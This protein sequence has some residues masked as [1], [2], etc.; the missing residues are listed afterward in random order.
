MDRFSLFPFIFIVLGITLAAPAQMIIAHRGASHDA[1]ENTL[2]AFNLAWEQGADGIEGDFHLTRDGKII[3]GHDKDMKR[4]GG[5]NMEIAT[6]TF[7]DLRKLDVGSWKHAKF[8]KE[9]MPTLVEVFATVPAGKKIFI[10]IKCGPEIVPQLQKEVEGAKL[11]P[12]QMIVI[13]FNAD[14]IAAVRKQIPSIKAHWLTSYKQD[15]ATGQWSPSIEQV[16][17]TLKR[18]DASGLDTNA[19]ALIDDAFVKALR[20]EKYELH[21]W[22]VDEP[23]LARRFIKLGVDSITTNKP[24]WLRKQL[25]LH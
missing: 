18:I 15:K 11:K 17:A 12:E 8:A 14:V 25:D 16:I 3:C 13:S 10:E 4:T 6:S 1:P 5:S 23:A 20:G 22:T 24:A 21:C 9:K 19:H 2:T 7:D